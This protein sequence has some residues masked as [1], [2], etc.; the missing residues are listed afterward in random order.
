MEKDLDRFITAQSKDYAIALAEISSGKKRSHWMWYIFPQLKGLGSSDLARYYGIV[1]LD[2]ATSYL[3]HPLLGKNLL[4]IC[5][6]LQ[7]L[8]GKTAHDI[9]NSPDDLKLRSCLTLFSMV[10]DTSP[11]FVAL[12]D[13]YFEGIPDS[14][15]VYLLRQ[16]E[17]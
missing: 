3:R 8:Q 16:A 11:L 7:E 2:E 17:N 6:K 12:I 13:Q 9:F 4:E 1:S 14:R 10:Q 5:G 15:T